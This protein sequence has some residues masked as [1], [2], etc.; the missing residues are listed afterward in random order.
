MSTETQE[1]AASGGLDP[2]L[3]LISSPVELAPFT[4]PAQSTNFRLKTLPI[5][6]VS[7][8]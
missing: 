6:L 2:P 1:P 3:K 5:K 8:V 4:L 7:L